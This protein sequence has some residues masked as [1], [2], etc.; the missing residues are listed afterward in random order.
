MRGINYRSE[1]GKVEQFDRNM[2]ELRN[3]METSDET[4]NQSGQALSRVREIIVQASN[5]TYEEEQRESMSK[6]VDQIKNHLIDLANTKVNN[7]YIFNGTN[8]LE[9]RFTDDGELIANPKNDEAVM[10]EVSEGIQIKQ[11][12]IHQMLSVKIY[13]QS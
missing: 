2:G 7:K 11:T 3:W 5:D 12:L 6:E 9:A 13:L 10:I 1:L 4:M 8:T